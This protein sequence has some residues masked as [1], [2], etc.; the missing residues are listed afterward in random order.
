MARDSTTEMEGGSGDSTSR[1]SEAKAC[2]ST[3]GSNG[4]TAPTARY[5]VG[6]HR[7]IPGPAARF[8]TAAWSDKGIE[9]QMW[10]DFA[11]R[12]VGVQG[13]GKKSLEMLKMLKY[14]Y[15]VA[16]AFVSTPSIVKINLMH[17]FF[18]NLCRTIHNQNLHPCFAS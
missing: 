2:V 14:H 10:N 7:P 15:H 9:M 8:V 16:S 5:P 18:L 17:L 6:A 11:E 12:G 1:N 3:V 4:F 13:F